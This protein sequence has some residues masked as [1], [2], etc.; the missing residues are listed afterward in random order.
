MYKQQS[1][2]QQQIEQELKTQQKN[3][4]QQQQQMK[5]QIDQQMKSSQKLKKA[6][7]DNS[8]SFKQPTPVKQNKKSKIANAGAAT[9]S[10]NQ[11]KSSDQHMT[12]QQPPI[13]PPN[14][15]QTAIPNQAAAESA[16]NIEQKIEM[17]ASM[18]K[19]C[20]AH[21]A[22]TQPPR[23]SSKSQAMIFGSSIV[24]HIKGNNIWKSAHVAA[25]TN[26][27]PGA[28]IAEIRDH[29]E[30]KLKYN[31]LP[32]TVI[33][34]GGGND[35]A[36]GM[37][38]EEI[39]AQMEA[40]CKDLK[41]KGITNISISGITPRY[42]LRTEVPKLNNALRAMCKKNGFDYISNSFVTYNYHLAWDKV[43]LNYD[44]VDQLE[45]NISKYL[46]WKTW[47]KK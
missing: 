36:D 27:Y 45:S 4:Q 37:E 14:P 9:A 22:K 1:E 11:Q 3:H 28:G 46:R 5:Q 39:T 15:K 30:V 18:Q 47:G 12:P 6:S 24:R 2:Q 38:V 13:I 31:P 42:L 35:L 33:I 23:K 7:N 34:H 21:V 8:N 41:V 19:E 17:A 29:I 44:G 40:L 26:C 20:E 25:K 32:Q 10:T 43:H 16:I